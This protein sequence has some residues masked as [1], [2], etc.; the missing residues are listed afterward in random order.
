VTDEIQKQ[1][2]KLERLVKDLLNYA[3][4]LPANYVPADVN[5]LADKILAFFLTSKEP[6]RISRLKRNSFP[7]CPGS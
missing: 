6:L 2:F 4:P 7:L 5:E 3:K 1:I